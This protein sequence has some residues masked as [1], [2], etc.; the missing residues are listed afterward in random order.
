MLDVRHI[1]TKEDTAIPT[2][3]TAIERDLPLVVS[4]PHG[5]PYVLKKY[6]EH[7]TFGDGI[8]VDNDMYTSELYPLDLGSS[9]AAH[10]CPHQVNLN[11]A[12]V[13]VEGRDPLNTGSYLSE[14]P[15][16]QG[17]W[18]AEERA[19]LE[20]HHRAYHA[21]LARLIA[22]MHVEYGYAL[23]I[24]CHALNSRAL[25]NTPDAGSTDRADFIIG[26]LDDTSADARV[27]DLFH[28]AL[29][30]EAAPRGLRVVRNNPYK[31]GHITKTWAQP[32]EGIH[33]LQLEIKKKMYMYE[34]IERDKHAFE[35]RESFADIQQV[36]RRA[37]EATR[38]G[39]RTI[40][41]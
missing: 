31:G 3:C 8:R 4:T 11:R 15:L 9:L 17:E 14:D 21:E 24:D 23:L 1:R 6:A 38:D 2:S 5:G 20:T 16:Y 10:L 32:Q 28:A 22:R 13:P 25:A 19:D 36:L 39:A 35:K 37:F 40:L 34:G 27:I 7:F 18:S 26:S 12:W 41:G 30:K 33:A 29:E